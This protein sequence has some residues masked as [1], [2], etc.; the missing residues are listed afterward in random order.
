MEMR[1]LLLDDF[2]V[3]KTLRLVELGIET[4]ICGAITRNLNAVIFSYGIQVIP[5]VAGDLHEVV[6]AWLRGCLARDSFV[7]PG[8]GRKRGWQFG[9][10][11]SR[12]GEVNTMNGRGRGMD[13]GAGKR[14]GQ[15]R[16][17]R[18]FSGGSPAAGPPDYCICPQCGQ[19]E[20]HERGVPCIGRKCRKCGASM[21]RQ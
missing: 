1:E 5:F 19:T 20:P 17:G 9:G 21:T 12:D 2:P 4:L 11:N 14:Q 7:M 3:Q 15:G 13:S 6:Q 18:G 16:R 10:M 8:C